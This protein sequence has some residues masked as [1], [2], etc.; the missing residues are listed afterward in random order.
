VEELFMKAILRAGMV[1][2]LLLLGAPTALANQPAMHFTED[3]TG[4]VFVCGARTYTVVSG[5]LSV[6]IHEGESA[7]G[8][9]NFTG[10]L[11]PH[12]VVAED[13]AGNTYSIRGAVWFGGTFNAQQGTEQGTFTAKLQIVA[14]GGGTVDSVNVVG[15]F[16]PN[17]KEFFLDFGTCVLPE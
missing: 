12:N 11:T 1:L 3:V 8:N 17:G 6:V 10:T 9:L 5:T 13:A 16:S 14:R 2:A 4:D 7:S 15:H